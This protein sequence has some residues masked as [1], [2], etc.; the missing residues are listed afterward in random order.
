MLT[1]DDVV[2][3]YAK[4]G[5]DSPVAFFF[6]VQTDTGLLFRPYDLTVVAREEARDDY[7][8][9]S[10]TGVM[11]MRKGQHAGMPT[12]PWFVQGAHWTLLCLRLQ[13]RGRLPA[14]KC[15]PC[16][17]N[18]SAEFIPLAD[19]Q[20]ERT[21]FQLISNITF[22]KH[23]AL[24]GCF[25]RWHKAK[26]RAAF[27]RIRAAVAERLFHAKPLFIAA[28][29]DIAAAVHGLSTVSFVA[30]TP[31]IYHSLQVLIPAG[32]VF[33]ARMTLLSHVLHGAG[34]GI[35]SWCLARSHH[36]CSLQAP[37]F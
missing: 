33:A 31:H 4:Y 12:R 7:Y 28:L 9:I 37:V 1:S 10:A 3:F 29:R 25:T 13:T 36:L 30:T 32:V 6:C 34:S 35:A 26:R 8:T 23:N 18:C 21:L 27:R 14:C 16:L 15:Q 5:Q 22:F 19:W 24:S 17:R 20:R 2:E 11:H